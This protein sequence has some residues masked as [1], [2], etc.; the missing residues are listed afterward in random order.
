MGFSILPLRIS[1][2]MGMG[3]SLLSVVWLALILIDKL[4]ISPGV[5][6]G[7]PTVLACIV[8]FSGVQLMVLGMLGE[9]LGRMFLATNGQPQYIVREIIRPHA[10]VSSSGQHE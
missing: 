3:I 1:S 6:S 10:S 4:W 5:T 9:Y 2:L 7:I 8:L